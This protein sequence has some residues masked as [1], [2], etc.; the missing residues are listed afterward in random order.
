MAGSRKKKKSGRAAGQPEL[1]QPEP[2]EVRGG[3]GE[4]PSRQEIRSL[5]ARAG[6]D[7]AVR[8]IRQIPEAERPSW[9]QLELAGCLVEQGVRSMREEDIFTVDMDYGP[10]LEADAILTALEPEFGTDRA[11]LM[12]SFLC[13]YY[14]PQR[15][16]EGHQAVRALLRLRPGEPA[17]TAMK[18]VLEMPLQS[19]I[20][21]YT[22]DA[23]RSF[24]R[25]IQENFGNVQIG[26]V[27]PCE[28]GKQ[29]TAVL[30]CQPDPEHPYQTLVS[31]GSGMYGRK[32][33]NELSTDPPHELVMFLP[34]KYDLD[35]TLKG[36][37]PS[38]FHLTIFSTLLA[39][40][41]GPADREAL[42]PLDGGTYP[43]SPFDAVAVLPLR[44]ALSCPLPG[45][46]TVAMSLAVPVRN[47]ELDLPDQVLA[48]IFREMPQECLT[49]DPDRPSL[50]QLY[51]EQISGPG[52][53]GRQNL[54][55]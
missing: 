1:R 48:W 23:W 16:Y 25:F 35:Q 36:P 33:Q 27:P 29:Q 51:R 20:Q 54:R 50:E 4:Q 14:L 49:A 10:L 21:Y 41:S 52:R 40:F 32:G 37:Y 22:P 12:Y 55:G 53:R 9:M 47:A 7:A 28:P 8:Q 5:K 44:R 24:L 46:R 19:S 26:Y 17:V 34:E 31:A 38:S 11:W 2:A 43:G 30:R 18:K 42:V 6:V 15:L 13:G 39:G 45:G 3:S